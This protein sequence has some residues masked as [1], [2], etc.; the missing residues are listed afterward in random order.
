MHTSKSE[1]EGMDGEFEY[2]SQSS[3]GA[4][5]GGGSDSEGVSRRKRRKYSA[6]ALAESPVSGH[7]SI[8]GNNVD[9][10]DDD[11]C[12][13]LGAAATTIGAQVNGQQCVVTYPSDAGSLR[14][15][16]LL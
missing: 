14:M 6:R 5:D 13:D 2:Y 7:Y 11:G 1:G 9:G 15:A 3:D 8:D 10:D 16:G 4:A 12:E